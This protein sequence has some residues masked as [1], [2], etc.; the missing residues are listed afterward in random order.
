M[1]QRGLY[2]NILLVVKGLAMGIANKVPG[3]SG[4]I[5]AIV[6]GFYPEFLLSLKRLNFN[7]FFMLITGKFKQFY[8][9][10]NTL[11][12]SLIALGIVLS[13][14]TVSRVLDIALIRYEQYVKALFFGMVVMSVLVLIRD[15]K[16]WELKFLLFSFIGLLVGITLTFLEP[17]SENRNLFFVFFCGFVSIIGM[18]IPGLSGSFLLILLGNYALLLVDAVNA[19]WKFVVELIQNP[20][21]FSALAQE[22]NEL[23][24]IL[25]IFIVGSIVGLVSISN[26]LHYIIIRFEER[27]SA[28]IIGF[29]IGSLP[30]LWPWSDFRLLTNPNELVTT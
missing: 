9:Y 5:V 19:V 8:R 4:G 23:L 17:A 6:T 22:Y 18:T 7:A 25:V 12:L 21:A 27:L 29:I 13:Y 1:N 10:T 15:F 11:F 20:S 26:L 24:T 14:F 30:I 16:K 28:L 3:V 2:D